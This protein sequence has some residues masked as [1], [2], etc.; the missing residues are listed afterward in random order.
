MR[1]L[2]RFST[3]VKLAFLAMLLGLAVGF[4]A[5]QRVAAAP[6]DPPRGGLSSSV[7]GIAGTDVEQR[8]GEF[9][10]SRTPT[11]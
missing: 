10:W 2:C 4:L 1:I 6:E 3:L 11:W 7:P 9:E 5:G 8:G